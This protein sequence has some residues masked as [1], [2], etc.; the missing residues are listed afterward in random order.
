MAARRCHLLTVRIDVAAKALAKVCRSPPWPGLGHHGQWARCTEPHL[1]DMHPD[2]RLIHVLP[3]F[4]IFRR[5]SPAALPA[6]VFRCILRTRHQDRVQRTQGSPS[7]PL[8]E[9]SGAQGFFF[10]ASGRH[11]LSAAFRHS[12]APAM[13]CSPSVCGRDSAGGRGLSS[14]LESRE[15]KQLVDAPNQLDFDAYVGFYVVLRRDLYANGSVVGSST[16]CDRPLLVD[17]HL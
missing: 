11:A 17:C 2:S 15:I 1:Q 14:V 7:P 8:M 4:A 3:G 5:S 12:Y 6:W 9:P 13:Q 10:R 16:D